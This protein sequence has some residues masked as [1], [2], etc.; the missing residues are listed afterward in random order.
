MIREELIS[1]DFGVLSLNH[2]IK[3]LIGILQWLLLAGFKD[4]SFIAS[5]VGLEF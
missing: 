2:A 3:W 1:K 5:I 4:I